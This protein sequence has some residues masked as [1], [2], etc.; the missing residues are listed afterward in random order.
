MPA[1]RGDR[2]RRELLVELTSARE[3][4]AFSSLL[5]LV[6]V[7]TLPPASYWASDA[8]FRPRK[9]PEAAPAANTSPAS[10]TVLR[11]RLL[12]CGPAGALVDSGRSETS[13]LEATGT[14][15]LRRARSI[16]SGK[17]IRARSA[18]TW[19]TSAS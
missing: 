14:T 16:G 9:P 17:S 18:S 8:C 3:G 10:T 7:R 19:S 2:V 15:G 5:P 4:T 1:V 13:G 11:Q 6:A 12:R